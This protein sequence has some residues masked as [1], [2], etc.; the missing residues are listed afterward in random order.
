MVANPFAP[1]SRALRIARSL[2]SEGYDVEIA[3]MQKGD[4]PARAMEGSIRVHRYATGP[5]RDEPA[6]WAG[7]DEEGGKKRRRPSKVE[8]I[9]TWPA[10]ASWPPAHVRGWWKTLETELE[11]ADLYHG[12]GIFGLPPALAARRRNR[13]R[14][15]TVIYD[16]VDDWFHSPM[17][18]LM[19]RSARAWQLLS[20]KRR[21]LQSDAIVTINE[22]QSAVYQRRW[23]PPRRVV[24]VPN[25]PIIGDRPPGPFDLIRGKLGLPPELKIVLYVGQVGS[26]K[27]LR[28]TE[29][30]VLKVPGAALVLVGFGHSWEETRRLDS[31]PRFEGR[32]FTLPAVHPDELLDWTASADVSLM[33]F[34]ATS[35]NDRRTTPNK[36]WEAV[37]VGTPV[38]VGRGQG[39]MARFVEKNDLGTVA[40]EMTPDS[41]AGA[42]GKILERPD[43]ERAAWRARMAAEA[44]EKWTWP[45]AEHDYLAELRAVTRR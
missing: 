40:E 11:P 3:A 31:D 18:T 15:A 10:R 26:R 16:V 12:I 32:H 20:E 13:G 41:I 36:L 29:E 6:A 43:E 33:R 4:L 44:H 2:E 19:P 37:A 23:N 9:R 5:W 30:A 34:R 8:L 17:V 35:P 42:I 28:L 39:P 7:G 21:A 14:P 38:V 25:Y 1:Y 45:V 27:P 24:N 22:T